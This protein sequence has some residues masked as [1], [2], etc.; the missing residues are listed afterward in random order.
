MTAR[1]ADDDEIRIALETLALHQKRYSSDLESARQLITYG[2]SVP[3]R[4]SDPAELAAWTMIANLLLNCDEVV[5][6]N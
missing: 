4:N 2:E 5:N 1:A 3:D 6:K